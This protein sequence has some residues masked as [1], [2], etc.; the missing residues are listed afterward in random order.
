MIR[1]S[2]VIAIANTPSLKASTRLV[3]T[4]AKLHRCAAG[5]LTPIAHRSFPGYEEGST[6]ISE[7][8]SGS[9]S[10][11]IGGTGSPKRVTASSTSTP[12]AF[13]AA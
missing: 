3:D 8:P 12:A 2:R 9:R 6:T 7:L 4:G 1:I 5:A 11:N 13:R 10:Q